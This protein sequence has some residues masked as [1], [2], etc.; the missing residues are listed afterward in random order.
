[1]FFGKRMSIGIDSDGRFINVVQLSRSRGQLQIEAATSIARADHTIPLDS[2]EISRLISVLRRQGFQGN[3]V[4][5]ALPNETVMTSILKMPDA[6][7]QENVNKRALSEMAASHQCSPLAIEA[8]WW[9]LPHANTETAPDYIMAVAC[10]SELAHAA[11][12]LFEE[13]G[14]VVRAIDVK[15][16][17]LTR[18]CSPLLEGSDGVTA[19]LNVGWGIAE[20]V[21]VQEETVIFERT[22]VESNLNQLHMSL[23]AKYALEAPVIDQLIAE[24]GCQ[25]NEG[26]NTKTTQTELVV[27]LRNQ[28]ADY[29]DRL[30]CE[31]SASISYA[32]QEYDRKP[33]TRLL[34]TGEGSEIPGIDERLSCELKLKVQVVRP[35]DVVAGSEQTVIDCNKANMLV[36]VGLASH[37]EG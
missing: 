7:N 10:R 9:N 22:L 31:L 25:S 35:L 19:I 13:C 2:E 37:P 34:I 24:I 15:P 27:A 21:I 26:E 28:I 17:A 36:A 14:M 4:V 32:T 30:S 8:S 3:S 29:V 6:D 11:V 5:L 33:V 12:D 18:A 16:C 1:M 20:M 23:V